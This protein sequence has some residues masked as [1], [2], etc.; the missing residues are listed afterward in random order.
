MT[1]QPTISIIVPV[2]PGGDVSNVLRSVPEARYPF[3]KIEIIV[4]EGRSPS[5]QRNEAAKMAQGEILYFLDN[6]VITDKWLFRNAMETFEEEDVTV[7]GGPTL[8]PESDTLKQ[9]CFGYVLASIFGAYIARERY[10]PLGPIRDATERELILCN[11]TIRKHTFEEEGGFNTDLYPNEE[12][13]FLNRLKI[14]GKRCVYH[15]LALVWRSQPETFRAFVKMI[16]NYGRGR[17]EHLYLSPEFIKPVFAGPS[18]FILYLLSL[19]FFH[20]HLYYFAPLAIYVMMLGFASLSIML[21]VGSL[22]LIWYLPFSFFVLHAS[23]GLGFMW[24]G[25]KKILGLKTRRTV[26]VKITR[27]KCLGEKEFVEQES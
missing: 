6:D 5:H 10:V 4:V 16:F 9:K 1:Y 14:K 17:F 20:P 21:G 23:Y 11:M 13:E 27:V 25:V 12:N 19:T 2:I 15:P 8:T 18:F 26:E 24:G 3:E 7:V 22:A